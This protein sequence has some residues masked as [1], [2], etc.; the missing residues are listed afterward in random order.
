MR[1]FNEYLLN[2]SE[3]VS[4]IKTRLNTVKQFLEWVESEELKLE[5]IAYNELMEYVASCKQKG[6]KVHTIRLKIRSLSVYFDFLISEKKL[7]ANPC[8]LVKLK[9]GVRTI[10]HNLL[11]SEELLEIYELQ[12][13]FGLTQKRNKVLLS[14]VIFQG[15]GRLDLAR[16][17][18]KDIDL[19][20]G[21]YTFQVLEPPTVEPCI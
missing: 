21:K 17:E 14:L 3:A 5:N 13:T 10:A 16:I 8:T 6:N 11:S 2:K 4:T 12:T 7:E 19:M 20:N 18:L 9:G 1:T 15:V